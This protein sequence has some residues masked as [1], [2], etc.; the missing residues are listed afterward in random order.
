MRQCEGFALRQW[1]H[2]IDRSRAHL[3]A[4][5]CITKQQI[6]LIRLS[7][8]SDTG[9]AAIDTAFGYPRHLVTVK[10]SNDVARNSFNGD[11]K[12]GMMS[13]DKGYLAQYR[14]PNLGSISLGIW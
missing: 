2:I 4:C 5:F 3:R 10:I 1:S 9:T 14:S 7:L 11:A 8:P 12:I 13:M 6:I